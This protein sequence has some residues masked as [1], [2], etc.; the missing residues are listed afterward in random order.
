MLTIQDSTEAVAAA[1]ANQLNAQSTLNKRFLLSLP[2]RAGFFSPP[3]LCFFFRR[4]IPS[5]V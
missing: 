2:E 4:K 5:F 1:S 3:F